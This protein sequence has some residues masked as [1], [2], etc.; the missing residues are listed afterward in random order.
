MPLFALSQNYILDSINENNGFTYK[1]FPIGQEPFPAVLYSHGG[2]GGQVGGNLRETCISLA[3]AGYISWCQ[4]RTDT[5]PFPLHITQV[6]ASLD[7]LLNQTNVDLNNIGIIGFSRGGLLTL[8]SAI[9]NYDHV[10]AVVTMAPASANNYLT[11]T[12]N[13]ASAID[14]SVLILVAE[15]DLYQDNHVQIAIDVFQ[16]LDTVTGVRHIQYDAYDSDNNGIINNLDDG[17]ELFW[18]VQQPYWIDLIQFLDNNL[19]NS[20]TMIEDVSN[21]CSRRLVTI[22]NIL[23]QEVKINKNEILFYIYDDGTVEKKIIIE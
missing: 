6:E 18:E 15:N 22:L 1:A 5:I 7:S 20:V 3:E 23:G 2:Y 8:I 19:K 9:N 4:L 14:D 21:N 10:N 13:Q 12:L 16:A 11:N 17:H